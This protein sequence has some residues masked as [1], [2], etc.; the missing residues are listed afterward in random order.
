M[1]DNIFCHKT[2]AFSSSQNE[3]RHSGKRKLFH[4]VFAIRISE[5]RLS[6]IE[7]SG[8]AEAGPLLNL[9]MQ[10]FLLAEV[11]LEQTLEGLAVAGLVQ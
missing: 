6:N 10:G 11:A 1:I 3:K 5:T 8:P 2:T 4:S 7:K 9:Q